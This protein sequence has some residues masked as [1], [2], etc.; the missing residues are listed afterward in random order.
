MSYIGKQDLI[1]ELGAEALLEI[2]DESRRGT[3][4][5]LTADEPAIRSLQAINRR[6]DRGIA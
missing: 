1:D 5:D 4:D 3:V 6:I 2:V